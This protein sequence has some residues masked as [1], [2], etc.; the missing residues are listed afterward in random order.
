MMFVCHNLT[1]LK[2][3]VIISAEPA[4]T[5]VLLAYIMYCLLEL[6]YDV[7][8]VIVAHV[9]SDNDYSIIMA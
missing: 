7:V 1:K 5:E 8:V 6:H 9:D 3:S 2:L 4:R